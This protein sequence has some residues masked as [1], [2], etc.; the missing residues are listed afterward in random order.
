[1]SL[2]PIHEFT[3]R[4]FLI[5]AVL[6]TFYALYHLLRNESPDG[7]FWGAVAVGEILAVV[8]AV[9]GVILLLTSKAPAR[10]IHFLYGVLSVLMWP[11]AY[12]YTRNQSG[13]RETL[14]WF[15]ISA[16]LAGLAWR[17]FVTGG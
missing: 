17:A 11:A 13:R 9:L 16:F 15:L 14:I 6:I 7:N 1:M 4:A 12:G 2:T 5:F 8:Q 3:G 10:G